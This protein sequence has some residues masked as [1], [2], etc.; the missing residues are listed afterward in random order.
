MKIEHVFKTEPY[1]RTASSYLNSLG[2][3]KGN[4]VAFRLDRKVWIR[5]EYISKVMCD[6]LER[7]VEEEE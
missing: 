4:I 1:A 6:L 7:F 5:P 2:R 3:N